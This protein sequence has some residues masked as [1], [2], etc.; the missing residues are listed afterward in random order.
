MVALAWQL[1]EIG[2]GW[3]RA[4]ERRIDAR[5]RGYGLLGLLESLTTY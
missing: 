1:L 2:N 4:V 5:E 3:I